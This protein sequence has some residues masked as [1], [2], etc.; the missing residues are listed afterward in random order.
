MNL[1]MEASLKSDKF[2]TVFTPTYNRY[3]TLHRVYD[4]ICSQTLQTIE[5]QYI[6][7]WI[8]VDDGSSD[9]TQEL[10]KQWQ[11]ESKFKI[12]YIYQDNQGKPAA[13][14][15]G[16][17]IA[18]SELFLIAD[19]DDAFL[20]ETFETFYSIWSN[21]SELE[22]KKCGGISVRCKDQYNHRIGNDFPVEKELVLTEKVVFSWRSK[23]FGETWAALKTKNLKMY[24]IIPKEAQNLK[25]IPESFFWHRITLEEKPYT[26]LL[27][28]VLR[29][30]YVNEHQNNL[31]QNIRDN[32]ASSFLF[33]S[34]WFIKKYWW[35]LFKYPKVYLKH[36]LKYFYFSLKVHYE[37]R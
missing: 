8:I 29:I 13:T 10:I 12:V 25:F 16:I 1:G 2:I 32:F 36:L 7:E 5:D 26:Y 11:S 19:S 22:K 21:F 34:K 37:T 6:F 35:V 17:E 18:Q 33:E 23:K 4:S 3:H 15:K 9:N 24:F 31:S 20:P 30:Y 14:R 28:M 27:N